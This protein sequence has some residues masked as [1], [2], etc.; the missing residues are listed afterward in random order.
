MAGT[1]KSWRELLASPLPEAP[2]EGQDDV[3]RGNASDKCQNRTNP[4]SLR[5]ELSE[6]TIGQI[7]KTSDKSTADLCVIAGC[8]EPIAEGDL[9][10]CA[11]HRVKADDGALWGPRAVRQRLEQTGPNTWQEAEWAR[12]LCVFCEQA[13]VDVIAC[14][15]HRARIDAL[16]LDTLPAP[17][18]PEGR[19]R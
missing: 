19:A 14:A 2:K 9:V 15:E 16:V 13:A 10:Y 7:P 6:T 12:G 17:P 8:T 1:L 4:D 11:V 5:V 3:S 18:Q